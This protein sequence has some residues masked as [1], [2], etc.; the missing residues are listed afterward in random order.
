MKKRISI[1]IL[2]FLLV[3]LSIWP[4]FSG[5]TKEERNSFTVAVLPDTQLYSQFRPHIYNAQTQ[6]IADNKEGIDLVLHVGDIVNRV[7]DIKQWENADAAMRILDDAKVPYTVVTGNHDVDY[8]AY[9]QDPQIYHDGLRENDG[10]FLT[11]FPKKR[12]SSMP[13]YGGHSD[14]GFNQYHFIDMGSYKVLVLALDWMPS[15]DTMNWAKKVLRTYRK[16]PTIIVKH[17]FIKP[18]NLADRPR[19][20][21]PRFSSEQSQAQ[22]EE[23]SRYD[24]VFMVINGHHSGSDHGIVRNRQGEDVYLSVVD[25]QNLKD[26]GEGW[27]RTL[28]FD[29][30][31]GTITGKTF[32][33]F[34][35]DP[36]TGEPSRM[37]DEWN[38][39]TLAFNLQ[40]RFN[41]IRK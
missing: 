17:E 38:D 3:F 30:G 41:G 33:P 21:V 6:W 4:L 10:N 20:F 40:E 19:E 29:I 16:Y 24:Q 7:F 28:E 34:L 31:Q 12:F 18:R 8:K 14:N 23:F 5:G 39:F 2:S 22:W 27:M 11:Y 1:A 15:E 25:F 36:E 26:G 13:T 9:S 37:L 35:A 32:S